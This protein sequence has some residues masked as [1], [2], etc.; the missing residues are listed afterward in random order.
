MKLEG[1]SGTAMPNSTWVS[2]GGRMKEIESLSSNFWPSSSL[3]ICNSGNCVNRVFKHNLVGWQRESEV[4]VEGTASAR[5]S[6]RGGPQKVLRVGMGGIQ[7]DRS[8]KRKRPFWEKCRTSRVSRR[9]VSTVRSGR[10][11]VRMRR[12]EGASLRFVPL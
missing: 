9:V 12:S 7:S 6:K 11:P 8:V 10:P 3:K 5:R 4:S 2:E 1:D